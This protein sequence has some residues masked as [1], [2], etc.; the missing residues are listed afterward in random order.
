MLEKK[1]YVPKI[2]SFDTEFSC[3]S[4]YFYYVFSFI[5]VLYIYI[6]FFILYSMSK[7]YKQTNKNDEKASFRGP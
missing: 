6:F 2:R 5:L 4:F 3:G 7:K 1:D